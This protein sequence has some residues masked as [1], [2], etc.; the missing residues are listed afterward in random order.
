VH[1]LGLRAGCGTDLDVGLRRLCSLVSDDNPNFVPYGP[2]RLTY[3]SRNER[4]GS[5]A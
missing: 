1:G 4:D 3:E 5:G 2:N